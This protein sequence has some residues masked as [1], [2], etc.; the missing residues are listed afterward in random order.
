MKTNK[1]TKLAIIPIAVTAILLTLTTFA[2]LTASRDVNL[3]GTLATVNVEVYS[4]SAYTQSCTAVNVGT[5]NPGSSVSQ[6]IYIKNTGTIP[7]TLSMITSN[8]NPTT[9]SSH[10]TL[11]WNRQNHLLD[12]EQVVQATLTL[13]AASNVDSLK[14]FSF[15]ATIIGTQTD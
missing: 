10:L 5:L 9:A 1:I 3:N 11:S 12:T 13:T 2:A 6:I 8:W 14:T 15:T 7:V 4:D